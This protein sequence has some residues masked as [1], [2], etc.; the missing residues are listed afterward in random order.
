MD[1]TDLHFCAAT[2]HRHPERP[3]LSRSK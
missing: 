1:F 3:A 2:S